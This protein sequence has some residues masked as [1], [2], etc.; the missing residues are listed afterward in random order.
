LAAL[1][2]YTCFNTYNTNAGKN[3]KDEVGEL[4]EEVRP[5][6]ALTCAGDGKPQA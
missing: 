3:V 2:G 6:A 1:I 5:N 4:P